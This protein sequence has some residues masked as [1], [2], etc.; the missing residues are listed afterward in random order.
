MDPISTGTVVVIAGASSGI[1][2]ATAHAFAERGA[3]LLLAARR[4]AHGARRTEMLAEVARQSR[5]LGGSAFA[6]GTD[7]SREEDVEKLARQAIVRFGRVD[8]WFNN[9]GVG[10]FG[11]LEDIPSEVWRRVIETDVFGYMYGAKAAIRQ[12]R[13]RGH[14]IPINDVSIVGVLAKPD[15][16][17]YATGKFAVR[18]FSEALRQELLDQPGIH[19]CTVLPALIDTPCFEHAANCSQHRVRAAPPVH[20][21]EKVARAVVD[22]VRFP[23]AGIVV[24]GAGRA[25]I[26]LK[27]PAPGLMTRLD[28]RMLHRGFLTGEPGAQTSGTLCEPM[29]DGH[30]VRGGWHKGANNGG[31]PSLPVLAPIGLP[32]GILLWRRPSRTWRPR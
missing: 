14:G 13:T 7:V 28:A 5:D 24:G 8:L 31:V 9:A 11:R 32:L 4:T 21:P 12:F 17:A 10:V 22:L 27:R 26:L 23:R 15:S 25:A 6:L 3:R 19:V 29:Y 18:G 20:T 16:T 2:R 1:G 30:G